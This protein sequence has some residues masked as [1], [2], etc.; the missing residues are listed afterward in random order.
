MSLDPLSLAA[1]VHGHLGWLAVAVVAHPVVALRARGERGRVASWAAT[2]VTT[3]TFLMGAFVYPTYRERVR[4]TLWGAVPLAGAWFERKEHLAVGALAFAWVGL[5][6]CELGRHRGARGGD[7]LRRTARLA[8]A[9]AL[10]LIV[11]VAAVG[12]LVS[13]LRPL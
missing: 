9:L 5:A 3:A 12:T 1:V 11:V 4:A 7:A 6:A 2:L 10:A 13:T 8:Y